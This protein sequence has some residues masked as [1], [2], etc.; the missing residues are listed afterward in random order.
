MYIHLRQV[1]LLNISAKH[2]HLNCRLQ[3]IIT[4]NADPPLKEERVQ[5]MI[6][7]RMKDLISLF[8]VFLMKHFSKLL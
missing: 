3:E 2:V 4:E 1:L 8:S 5:F 7:G 6:Q